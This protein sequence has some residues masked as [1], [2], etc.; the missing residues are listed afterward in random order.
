MPSRSIS[1]TRRNFPGRDG[2]DLDL[3]LNSR[4]KS[5][6]INAGEEEAS[7]IVIQLTRTRSYMRLSHTLCNKLGLLMSEH[8]LI[9]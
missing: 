2:R 4:F 6:L 8:R 9:T 1:P 3:E 5:W 7:G